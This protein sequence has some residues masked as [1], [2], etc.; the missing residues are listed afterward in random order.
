[1]MT[2]NGSIPVNV[3]HSTKRTIVGSVGFTFRLIVVMGTVEPCQ[4]L[5][6]LRGAGM[7]AVYIGE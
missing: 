3:T 5:F 6:W 7:F 1:M 2:A 4:G